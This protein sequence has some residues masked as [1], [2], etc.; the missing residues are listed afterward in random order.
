MKTVSHEP[1]KMNDLFEFAHDTVLVLKFVECEFRRM[2]TEPILL[3]PILSRSVAVFW[4]LN[5]FLEQYNIM[6]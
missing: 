6:D 2:E 1:D 3:I 5:I 4:H